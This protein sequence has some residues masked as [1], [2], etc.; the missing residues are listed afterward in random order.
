MTIMEGFTWQPRRICLIRDEDGLVRTV[1]L[2]QGRNFK[3]NDL[4]RDPHVS[5]RLSK[6]GEWNSIKPH[7]GRALWRDIS[8]L[9]PDSGNKSCQP[10]LVVSI[11]PNLMDSDSPLSV[12]QIGVVIVNHAS[13]ESWTEDR[14]SIP[15]C[16]V[17]DDR[18]AS[19]IREDAEETEVM[20]GKLVQCLN[21]RFSHD[22]KHSSDLAEQA[23][24]AFL[25][26]MHDVLFI[27]CIPDVYRFRNDVTNEARLQHVRQ[28]HSRLEQ[29]LLQ[30][31]RSVVQTSGNTARDLQLQ[32]EAQR[33]VIGQFR[34]L[35]A[36]REERYE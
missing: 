31:F 19:L 7:S 1:A 33:E 4:W 3:G 2:Q 30:T 9:L 16:L 27:F 21:N 8:T 12:R 22:K 25:A 10:P 32:V 15:V 20:Q 34:K 5:Y 23:R 14:L 29:A 6:K 35:A 13:Y 26:E 11:A 18:L 36:E 28:F 24:L 17:E